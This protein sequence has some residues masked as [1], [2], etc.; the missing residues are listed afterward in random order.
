MFTSN[1][2]VLYPNL[3][4]LFRQDAGRN[5][6][7]L[8]GAQMC[9]AD[10]FC[11]FDVWLATFAGFDMLASSTPTRKQLGWN[12]TGPDLFNRSEQHV[13]SRPE[14]LITPYLLH[15]FRNEKLRNEIGSGGAGD[16]RPRLERLGKPGFQEFAQL[17]CRLELGM[18]SS[19]LKAEVN[20]LERLQ[21]V[22]GQNSS[23]FGSQ[24]GSLT[25]RTRC[26]GAS[27]LPSRNAS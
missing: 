3:P 8:A 1:A 7:R 11:C 13:I 27:S 5:S 15:C 22:R 2:L 20:S 21:M 19:S 10:P 14:Q 26:F 17:G 6:S 24:Y 18:Q 23:Y 12:P 4:G 16:C 25:V 9:T